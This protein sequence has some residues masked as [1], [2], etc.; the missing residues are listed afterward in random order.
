M[1]GAE[2]LTYVTRRLAENGLTV[3]AERAAELYDYITEGRDVLLQAFA[4]AAPVVVRS[5]VTLE[6][7]GDTQVWQFP[8]AT[9]DPY[10]VT[11][12]YDNDGGATLTP[13]ATLNQDGGEYRWRSI[14]ELEL[15]ECV[16]LEGAP[17]VECVLAGSAIDAD[18][19]A[20]EIGLPVTCHRA[21]GKLAAVLALTA[22]EESDA[23]VAG[24]L[25]EAELQRL[26]TIYGDYDTGSGTS[27]RQALMA[28][29]GATHF[30]SLY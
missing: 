22:D 12:V 28:S 3:P 16:E 13:A 8:A 19:T 11:H 21:I 7:V 27:L 14:R 26:E 18:T 30:D 9:L 25:F 15:A 1:T 24:R 17:E 5:Y 10:R 20:A 2:L 23:G 6:Q 4:V 29:V